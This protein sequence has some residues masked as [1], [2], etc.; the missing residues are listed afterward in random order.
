MCFGKIFPQFL[1]IR[2]EFY[3]RH[4]R[5]IRAG[6]LLPAT[7]F[8]RCPVKDSE[9]LLSSYN[10]EGTYTG[11]NDS[12][13]V[14]YYTLFNSGSSTL[15][16]Y[17]TGE[18]AHDCIFLTAESS[19]PDI[20]V[21]V[22]GGGA[23]LVVSL[24]SAVSSG[25][26][27]AQINYTYRDA[28]NETSWPWNGQTTVRF[29]ESRSL[30]DEEGN[31][32][33]EIEYND[34]K[35]V[36]LFLADGTQVTENTFELQSGVGN[37]YFY[38]DSTIGI[39]TRGVSV[40]THFT[41]FANDKSDGSSYMFPV[42]VGLPN[43]GIYSAPAV[44]E[45]CFLS[46]DGSW[47]AFILNYLREP[48]KTLYFSYLDRDILG[49]SADNPAVH[50]Q[51]GTAENGRTYAAVTLDSSG[52]SGVFSVTV[53]IQTE[54]RTESKEI[55]YSDGTGMFGTGNR[56]VLSEYAT[57][58]K[59][60][61][62]LYDDQGNPL[63]RED[64]PTLHASLGLGDIRWQLGYNGEDEIAWN[65]PPVP[66]RTGLFTAVS[67]DGNTTLRLRVSVRFPREP[68]LGAFVYSAPEL[69]EETYLGS[70]EYNETKYGTD[71]LAYFNISYSSDPATKTVYYHMFASEADLE[72]YEAKSDNPDIHVEIAEDSNSLI[73]SLDPSVQSGAHSALISYQGLDHGYSWALSSKITFTDAVFSP[74]TTAWNAEWEPGKATARL[75]L[76]GR[77]S[78]TRLVMAAYDSGGRMAGLET[79]DISPGIRQTEIE[80]IHPVLLEPG[81][82][83]KIFWLDGK[84]F[85]PLAEPLT[86]RIS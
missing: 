56:N 6:V 67:A 76:D 36:K 13:T 65:V 74:E 46:E 19:N 9:N 29:Y 11:E 84:T 85:E 66:G 45:S 15:R 26:R 52:V 18:D 14:Y 30:H 73:L 79:L 70:A 32:S 86:R 37:V 2:P 78:P 60:P 49:A 83:V 71:R 72:F 33:A 25:T 24:D 53:H 55:V 21:S 10:Y 4:V 8:Y 51:T 38:P 63:T 57:G 68:S 16:S 69:T 34:S 48:G 17:G 28:Q 27:S 31:L 75:L 20:H 61:F 7:A 12:R 42:H 47:R 40:G 82:T 3:L 64:F 35:I 5:T 58:R 22:G 59:R 44:D 77:S 39:N 54:N 50:V 23:Y 62:R 1:Y 41:V 80:I 81:A 43:F